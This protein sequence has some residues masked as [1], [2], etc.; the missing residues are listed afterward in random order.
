MKGVTLL[1]TGDFQHPLWNKELK[2]LQDDG[3]GILRN[4]NGFPFLLTTE[5][6]NIFT[7][8]GKGRRIHSL[9]FAPNMDIVDQ[10]TETLGKKGRLDYDGRPIFG[11]SCIELVE[12]MREISTDIEVIPAHVW[13]PW[14]GIFG[15]KSGFDSLQDCYKDQT[16]HIHAIETGLSSDPAMNWRLSALDDITMVS[17]SDSHSFWPWRMGREVT[18]FDFK[19]LS[20]QNILNA[21]RTRKGLVQTIETDPA[22]GKYHWDGHRAC[23]VSLEPKQAR[24]NRNLCPKCGRPLTIG[25][26]HRV[27]ELAD[28]PVG[29]QPKNTVPFRR[30]IPLSEIIAAVVGAA[31]PFSKKVWEEYYKLQKIGDTEFDIL[32]ETPIEKLKE[33]VHDKLADAIIK[34]RDG[35]ITIQP[36]YDGVYGFPVFDETKKQMSQQTITIDKQK[37]L[38]DF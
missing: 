31:Q 28:R 3:T 20:Y 6:A 15:S 38:G 12:M 13:T 36:G 26:E 29:F 37:N 30:L 5:I 18:V 34:T 21:I 23:N 25:V 4:A 2:T 9:I 27:E 17:F 8:D 19:E 22:Y 11:F 16:K 24:E 7:Q 33:A 14:F 1:G 32:L 10:I 35:T